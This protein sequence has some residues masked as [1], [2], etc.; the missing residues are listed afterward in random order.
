MTLPS[1]PLS[2]VRVGDVMHTGILTTDPST[3]L[4]V[5]A[6]LMAERHVHAVAVADPEHARRPWGIVDIFDVVAAAAH[7]EEGTAGEAATGEVVTISS[8]DTLDYAAQLM[9][10]DHLGHLIVVDPSSGHPEGVLSSL[11]VATVYGA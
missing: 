9:A 2:H 3:P 8:T 1:A 5:V 10:R 11:D 6:R 7:G 4:P